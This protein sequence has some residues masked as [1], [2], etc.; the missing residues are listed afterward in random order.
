M[1]ELIVSLLGRD[2]AW[3]LGRALYMRARGEKATNNIDSNGE[4]KLIAAILR[5][6]RQ[7]PAVLFDVGANRGEWT[8][9]ALGLA[10]EPAPER[11][12]PRRS[13]R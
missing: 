11:P 13:R 12:R 1:L 5:E 6:P 9:A 7:R 2:R 4:A 8:D 3:R 10:G